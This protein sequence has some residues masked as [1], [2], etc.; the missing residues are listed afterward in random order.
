MIMCIFLLF[1]INVIYHID[2][3]SYVEL[4]LYSKA[5]SHLFIVYNPFNA[6]LDLVH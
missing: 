3:F 4:S 5:Q 1:S 6:L 2:C